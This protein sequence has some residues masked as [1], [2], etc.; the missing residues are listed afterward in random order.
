MAKIKCEITPIELDGDYETVEGDY[1]T[2]DG[3]QAT[4]SK[5]EHYTESYGTGDDSI[6][7]CLALLNNE[8]PNKENNFYVEE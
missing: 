3:V 2:V 6:K 5:C 4:C 1:V 7:R 8:C